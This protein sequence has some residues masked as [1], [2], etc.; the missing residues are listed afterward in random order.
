MLSRGFVSALALGL[1]ACGGAASGA[2]AA[3]A[4][5]FVRFRG[6]PPAPGQITDTV[7]LDGAS[8]RVRVERNRASAGPDRSCEGV[9]PDGEAWRALAAA[10]ADADLQGALAQPERVPLLFLDAGYFTCGRGGVRVGVSDIDANDARAPRETA[11]LRRLQA[12]YE[13]FH[14]EVVALPACAGL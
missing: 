13:R 11:A 2:S 9:A 8:R 6:G 12:A 4:W 14:R 5:T 10:L 7:H 3:G 1:L